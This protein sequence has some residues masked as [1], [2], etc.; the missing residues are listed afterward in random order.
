MLKNLEDDLKKIKKGEVFV[1]T[2]CLLAEGITS[3]QDLVLD[4]KRKQS[5]KN[6][7]TTKINTMIY[8]KNPKEK[9]HRL[10]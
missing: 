3:L 8:V 4:G 7:A 9:N 1:Y 2:I 5:H 10:S 6:N